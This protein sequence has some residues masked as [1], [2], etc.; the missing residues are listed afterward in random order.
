LDPVGHFWIG[1][2]TPVVHYCMGGL[3]INDNAQVGVM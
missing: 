3:E 1:Q 2:I